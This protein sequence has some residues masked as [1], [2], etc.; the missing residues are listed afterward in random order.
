MKRTQQYFIL[1][2]GAALLFVGCAQAPTNVYR[3]P[4]EQEID[5]SGR[6]ND[7]DSQKVS[8]R[9]IA[10]CLNA[11][12]IGHFIGDT[13]EMP[14]VVV[15]TIYNKTDEH[16]ASDV[17]I[18]DLE[19]AFVQS[20]QV[21]VIQGGEALAEIREIRQSQLSFT[22]P[23]TRRFLRELGAD[24]V[25]QGTI[26]K[27]TDTDTNRAVYYYQVDLELTDIETVEKVWIDQLPVKKYIEKPHYGF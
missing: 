4:P 25:L 1:L 12:W 16:I 5:L 27:I 24:F 17:F 18:N 11:P 3:V 8:E 14:V 15:G 13:G 21:K 6:W 23:D 26:N 7:T 2:I 10:S 22:E 19:G 20:Q 9:M